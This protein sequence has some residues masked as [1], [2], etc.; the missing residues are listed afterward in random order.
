MLCLFSDELR[1]A[2][3]TGP[4]HVTSW[5]PAFTNPA[6]FSFGL[7]AC[8]YIPDLPYGVAV[9][10]EHQNGAA[11]WL[12]FAHGSEAGCDCWWYPPLLLLFIFGTIPTSRAFNSNDCPFDPS[13]L[14]YSRMRS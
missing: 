10:I 1:H 7:P 8:R 2:L 12:V 6:V 11:A 9:A 5:L 4:V 13:C 14:S 3:R